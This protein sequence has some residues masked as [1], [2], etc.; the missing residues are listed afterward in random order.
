MRRRIGTVL[1]LFFLLLPVPL[2]ID[3]GPG[4]MNVIDTPKAYVPYRGDLGFEFSMYDRGGILASAALGISDFALL[5]IYFD[6]GQLIGSEEVLVNPPGV[7]ARFLLTDGDSFLPRLALGFSYFMKGEVHKVGGTVVSG[8]YLVGTS[9]YFLFGT[10]QTISYGLRY[11]VVPLDYS[12]PG[13]TSLFLGTDIELGPAFGIKG[14]IENVQFVEDWWKETF[15]NLSFGF[16]IIDILTIS[17][18][19]KYSPSID[20][21]VRLLK[22]GYTT[23]F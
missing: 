4:E 20:R 3:A 6:I 14:E 22:I 16:S 5:G 9:G 10:E 21:V 13:H 12:D 1:Y 19:L 17:L 15:Y 23:Q 8:L 7:I 18:E 2:S 11:P